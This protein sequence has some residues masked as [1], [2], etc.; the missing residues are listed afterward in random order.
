[1]TKLSYNCDDADTRE[2][3][4]AGP[5]PLSRAGQV[6]VIPRRLQYGAAGGLPTLADGIDELV[7]PKDY[8]E[9][10]QHCHE[11][12]IFPVY[13]E[14]ATWRPQGTRWSQ[15]GLNY[16]WAWSIVAGLMDLRAREGKAN[17]ML[18][19]VSLGWLVNWRNDGNYLESAIKGLKARGVCSMEFT[20]DPHSRRPGSFR[21]AWED[22]ALKYRLG[23][24]WDCDPR[25][26][27]QH[28]ISGLRTGSP[29]YQAHYWWSHA[30]DLVAVEWDERKRS[31]LVWCV[32]N[33]HNESDIIRLDG[34][35][36]VPDELYFL[37]ASLT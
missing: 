17:V 25:S 26:M 10:I 21:D 18:S 8:K 29:G 23:E 6:G 12:R 3:L 15:N 16:C 32:C 34:N 19:P 13:H 7:D 4:L 30:T 28:A 33:S 5:R 36:A 11:Q 20:P 2:R 35:H 22:D 31:N 14:R 24:L 27:I 1:V 37:R 9:V